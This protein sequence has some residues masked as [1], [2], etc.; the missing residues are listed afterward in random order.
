MNRLIPS[1]PAVDL[2]CWATEDFIVAGFSQESVIASLS[3]QRVISVSATKLPQRRD[4]FQF[5]EVWPGLYLP[6]V[7]QFEAARDEVSPYKT[8]YEIKGT[9]LINRAIPDTAFKMPAG[10][11][12][13]L[14][15]GPS[16]SSKAISPR[17]LCQIVA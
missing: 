15:Q 2:I 3:D 12:L 9:I 10:V 1:R 8:R 17:R 5:S 16:E 6:F 11:N 7:S 13:I 4:F 14:D